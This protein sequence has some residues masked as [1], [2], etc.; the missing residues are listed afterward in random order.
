ML[1]INTFPPERIMAEQCCVELA[2]ILAARLCRLCQPDFAKSANTQK[3]TS[4]VLCFP[5]EHSV[6]SGIDNNP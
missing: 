4:F 6:H 1:Q 5:V 3:E 2:G